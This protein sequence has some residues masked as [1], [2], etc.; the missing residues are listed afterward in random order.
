MT[1]KEVTETLFSEL[2]T[3][4]KPSKFKA[5][6][7]DNAFIRKVGNGSHWILIGVYDYNPLYQV[8]FHLGIR[9]DEV[10]EMFHK[11][12]GTLPNYQHQ[13]LTCSTPIK[14]LSQE[15]VDLY[16]VQSPAEL[17]VVIR[18]FNQVYTK[19]GELFFSNHATAELLTKG[20]LTLG[21]GFNSIIT[22]YSYMKL[23]ILIRLTN[24][25]DYEKIK[26]EAIDA[27]SGLHQMDRNKLH[28]LVDYLDKSA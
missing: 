21:D 16:N 10:E 24:Q 17:A 4:L 2:S 27:C 12:S 3:I 1:K 23:L 19:Q 26:R 5:S 7:K 6:K 15:N 8:S 9:L 28:A 14:F 22:P 20:L 25:G 11:F 18:N 13:S